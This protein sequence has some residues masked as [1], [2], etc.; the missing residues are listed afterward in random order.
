MWLLHTSGFLLTQFSGSSAPP[1][2]ILSHTWGPEETTFDDIQEYC[3]TGKRP[4]LARF[5]KIEGCCAKARSDGY[6]YCWIDTC[7]IDKR[8][9]AE[10]SEAINSMFRWYENA[11]VC[12]AYLEDYLLGGSRLSMCRWFTRGW[13]LQELIAP[14]TVEFLAPDWTEIGTKINLQKDIGVITGISP[15]ILCR[16]EPVD[17][18][19][20]G[21]RMSWAARRKT[22][23][24]E[25]EAYCLMGLFGVHMPMLYGEGEKA[26][27]RLQL[28]IIK[29]SNDH[30][31]FAWNTRSYTLGRGLLAYSPAEF[32]DCGSIRM[33]THVETRTDD[34][35]FSMTNRGL[36]IK[37]PVICSGTG[38]YAILSCYSE[39]KPKGT[40]VAIRLVGEMT[41]KGI[42]HRVR[43]H[44][45]FHIPY[46]NKMEHKDVEMYVPQTR[47]SVSIL[48]YHQILYSLI[49]KNY[50]RHGFDVVEQFPGTRWLPH[51]ADLRAMLKPDGDIT[52][53]LFQDSYG[54]R[55]LVTLKTRLHI[56]YCCFLTDFEDSLLD[57]LRNQPSKIYLL[58]EAQPLD[59]I[60]KRLPGGETISVAVKNR[61]FY[62]EKGYELVINIS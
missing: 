35:P 8:S 1:Y 32:A 6:D 30:S 10:L 44:D 11:G 26:F 49:I 21:Q 2:A 31:I 52:S 56:V 48:G 36:F 38:A 4:E 5:L 19:S 33:H 57:R 41:L 24:P 53:I 55:F 15:E 51:D 62:G 22:T 45:I 39:V 14:P 61:C 7:C 25:D 28:E 16:V 40:S 27:E 42:Y 20:V 47:Q 17:S 12:Y 9:S 13:T 29:E 60:T 23:R 3:R 54:V 59:R 46:N 37:L 50:Q 18:A 58:V 34:K 43:C